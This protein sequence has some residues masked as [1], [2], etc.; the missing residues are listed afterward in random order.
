MQVGGKRSAANVMPKVES[1]V[2][3]KEMPPADY[4]GS[5]DRHELP[6]RDPGPKT[7]RK[8]NLAYFMPVTRP[9]VA[10]ILHIL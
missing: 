10:K 5:G 7:R 2:S 4:K 6:Q 9:L 8:R 1:V 3:R